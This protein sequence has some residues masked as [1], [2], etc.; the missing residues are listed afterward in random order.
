MADPLISWKGR[1]VFRLFNNLRYRYPE[2][3]QNPGAEFRTHRLLD[4]I[5]SQRLGYA[6]KSFERFN[7]RD[8]AKFHGP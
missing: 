3:H 7:T 2:N 5:G 4:I 8:C 1:I 6:W